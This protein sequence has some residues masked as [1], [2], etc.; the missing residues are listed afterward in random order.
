MNAR[1]KRLSVATAVALGA[2]WASAGH[3][4]IIGEWSYSTEATFDPTQTTFEDRTT[5]S[6][7]NTPSEISWGDP[8]GNF[9][10]G[11]LGRSALTIGQDLANLTG[12]GA[13]TGNVFTNDLGTVIGSGSFGEGP[14]FTHWNNVISSDEGRLDSGVIIDTLTLTPVA[15][16]DG[17][18]PPNT[19]PEDAPTLQIGF[20]FGETPNDGGDDELCEDGTPPS[21]GCVDLWGLTLLNANPPV[22]DLNDITF[23]YD[24]DGPGGND[25]VEYSLAIVLTDGDGVNASPI[26]ALAPGQCEALFG[27]GNTT[28]QGFTTPENQVTSAGFGFAQATDLPFG[29]IALIGIGLAGLGWRLRGRIA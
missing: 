18:A 15:D 5:N 24:G 19:A 9:Q 17:N 11:D 14:V 3:A 6:Y 1:L 4:L 20:V 27:P 29:S 26:G 21:G 2:T 12:G 16:L 13:V 10:T 22:G 23:T 8:L 28:C 25:P 7:T